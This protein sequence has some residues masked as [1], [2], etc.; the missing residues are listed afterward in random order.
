MRFDM[1][2]HKPQ[3]NGRSGISKIFKTWKF[4]KT[5][6]MEL[7]KNFKTFWWVGQLF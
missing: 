3:V 7:F 1:L 2:R 4:Y 6:E 5:S